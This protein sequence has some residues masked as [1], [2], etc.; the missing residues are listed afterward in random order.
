[1]LNELQQNKEKRT[2]T[3]SEIELIKTCF[4]VANQYGI[5]DEVTAEHQA[6]LDLYLKTFPL[7]AQAIIDEIANIDDG[8]FD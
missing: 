5:N 2:L 8:G 7:Q 3:Q 6:T 4:W 1:M